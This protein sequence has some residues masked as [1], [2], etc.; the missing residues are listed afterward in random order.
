MMS[1]RNRADARRVSTGRCWFGLGKNDA[2]DAM[3][4]MTQA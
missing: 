3:T 4:Q 2:G 1:I